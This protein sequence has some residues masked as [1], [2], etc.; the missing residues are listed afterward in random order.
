MVNMSSRPSV[1]Q[2]EERGPELIQFGATSVVLAALGASVLAVNVDAEAIALARLNV[3]RYGLANSI[4][5]RH[6]ADTR[7]LPISDGTMDIVSC[8]SVL[9]YVPHDILPAVQREIAR[10]LRP[11]GAILIMSTSSRLCPREVH[12]GVLGPNWLPRFV[13]RITGRS[14]QRGVWPWELLRDSGRGSRMPICWTDAKA[15]RGET[16]DG[17]FSWPS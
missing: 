11:G 5:I 12:S 7:Q 16:P 2:S 1:L 4:D 17:R 14:P 15:I 13:N 8:N 9:E 6:V 3:Q 10:V